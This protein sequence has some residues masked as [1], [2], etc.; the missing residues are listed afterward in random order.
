MTK[1]EKLILSAIPDIAAGAFLSLP[2]DARCKALSEAGA[3]LDTN[4]ILSLDRFIEIC[5]NN[6][7]DYTFERKGE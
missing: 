2:E 5:A 3:V 1:S 4:G 6:N 7:P